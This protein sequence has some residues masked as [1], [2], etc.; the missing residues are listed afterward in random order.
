MKIKQNSIL[1]VE[2]ESNIN[3]RIDSLINNF[4]SLSEEIKQGIDKQIKKTDEMKEQGE[5]EHLIHLR[6]SHCLGH[7]KKL[8]H[9]LKKFQ[10]VQYEFQQKEKNK[11][12][13]NYLIAC[14]NAKEED[15][16]DLDDPEKAEAILNAAF[17]IGSNS[18]KNIINEAKQRKTRIDKIVEQIGKLVELIEEI[19]KIVSEDQGTVDKIVVSMENAQENTQ[20]AVKEL[21]S[22]KDYQSKRNWIIKILS[23]VGVIVVIVILLFLYSTFK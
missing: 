17:S 8:S 12:R 11:L 16:K 15:L 2:D 23:V 7:S 21:K 5:N 6:E 22:A 10:N 4:T 20:E 19:D 18:A 1:T 9:A 3:I 14:P 13:E